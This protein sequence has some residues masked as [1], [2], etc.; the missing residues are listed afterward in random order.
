MRMHNLYSAYETP[1]PIRY[2]LSGT[3]QCI[4][5]YKYHLGNLV[6]GCYKSLE[7]VRVVYAQDSRRDPSW[8]AHSSLVTEV[9]LH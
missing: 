8:P 3:L 4:S 6:S 7:A 5:E 2:H 9:I 1:C